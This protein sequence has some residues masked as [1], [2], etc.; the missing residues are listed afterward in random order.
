AR[1]LVPPGRVGG[2]QAAAVGGRGRTHGRGGARGA[3]RAPALLPQPAAWADS[4]RRMTGLSSS[5]SSFTRTATARRAV[6]GRVSDGP[7]GAGGRSS[8]GTGTST[9]RAVRRNG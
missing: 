1:F 4:S 5:F 3:R 2:P 9:S 7:S 6:W 8:R